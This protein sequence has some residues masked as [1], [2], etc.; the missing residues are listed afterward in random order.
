M[1]SSPLLQVRD[2][3]VS[4]L[5]PDEKPYP[6]VKG[7]SF[8]VKRGE[9]LGLVGASGSGKSLTLAAIMGL[10]PAGLARTQGEIVFDGSHLEGLSQREIR[11]WRGRRMAMVFQD[12]MTALN[13]VMTVGKQVAEVFETHSLCPAGEYQARVTQL[14]AEVQLPNPA[15][16]ADR[17]PF[18]LSGGQRQRVLI[19]IALAGDPELLLADE[20]TTALDT[21]TQ[22]EILALMEKIQAQRCF[23]LIWVSHDLDVIA[24][25]CQK[26][27]VMF[28]GKIVE[29]GSFQ[30]LRQNPQH[31]HTKLLLNSRPGQSLAPEGKKSPKSVP[32]LEVAQLTVKHPVGR[33]FWGTPK[34]WNVAVNEVGFSL[35][36]GETLALVGESGCGKTSLGRALFGLQEFA[37][38]EVWLQPDGKSRSNLFTMPP[39]QRRRMARHLAMVFQDPF[40]SLNPRMRI[41]QSVAEPLVIHKE[42]NAAE[43]RK[44]AIQCLGQVGLG[45]E[46]S[47]R[48]PK[49]LS[50]GERQRVAI[51]RALVLNPS[52]IVCDEAVSALDLPIRKELLLLMKGLERD[53]GLA[54]LFITHDFSVVEEIADRVLVMEHGSIVESGPTEVLMARPQHAATKRLLAARLGVGCPS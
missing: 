46:F 43:Q 32:V 12:P 52:L 6:L 37:T 18:E 1:T 38:G 39:K 27:A 30:E 33:R 42:G 5:E 22:A 48:L 2:L 25:L 47:D 11:P 10:L 9:K 24:A 54:I 20:P 3:H 53:H 40:A 41:W 17:Y 35:N 8:E 28:E 4:A 34:T 31:P 23:T 19:A 15:S 29:S 50:G 51:A 21:T 45:Q 49:Q 26:V 44:L 36:R 13:P 16:L 14:F 7:V